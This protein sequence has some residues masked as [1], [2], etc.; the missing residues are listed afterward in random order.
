MHI[1]MQKQSQISNPNIK[2]KKIIIERKTTGA[3][4]DLDE[5]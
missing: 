1:Y 5:K 4:E 3:D 2:K